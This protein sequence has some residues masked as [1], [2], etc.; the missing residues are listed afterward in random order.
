[1][2]LERL[3]SDRSVALEVGEESG[4][5]DLASAEVTVKYS[6]YLKRQEREI[7][8]AKKHE[9]RRI[10]RDFRFAGIPGLS[11]EVVQRLDQVRPDTLGQ[12]ARIPGLTPAAV[13]VL[14]A[15]V[16]RSVS[17]DR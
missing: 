8:I 6:G 12:A 16:G 5:F 14:S 2:T 15:Y 9:R 1:V 3:L 13:A 7:E 11:K 17:G 10:P 4:D